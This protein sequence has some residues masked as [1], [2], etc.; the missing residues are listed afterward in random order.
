[1]K[2]MRYFRRLGAALCTNIKFSVICG[3]VS[4]PNGMFSVSLVFLSGLRRI[5]RV[6]PSNV[7]C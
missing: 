7:K 6:Y 5:G 4:L 3:I 1:M 2:G